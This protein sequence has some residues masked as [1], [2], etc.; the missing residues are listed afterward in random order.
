MTLQQI[1]YVLTINDSGT[2]ISAAEKLYISQPAL[3]ASLKD[4]EN[5]LG[6]RIFSRSPHGMTPTRDGASFIA[7]A[8]NLYQQYELLEDAYSVESNRRQE[9]GISTQHYSFVVQAFSQM[10]QDFDTGKYHFSL[11]ETTTTNII[12][13][14][15]EGRSEIGILYL[16]DYNSR[17]LKRLFTENQLEFHPLI[18]C[19]AYVYL[20][21]SH[22]LAD[23]SSITFEE[24]MDYPCLQFE[25]GSQGSSFLAEEILSDR[26]YLRTITTNDRATNLNLMKSINAYTLCSGIISEELN[27]SDYIAVP[28]HEDRRHRNQSM[29]IGYLIPRGS[30]LNKIGTVFIEEIQ[31]LLQQ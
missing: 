17:Y 14:V 27:G 21:K 31:K 29:T 26:E 10:L 23:R 28:F 1:R 15:A 8:R 18:K 16:S 2:M 4:L 9:F 25:Q 11:L 19:S 30:V 12:R 20:A 22:P 6:I 5:E 7:R 3:T 13:N 24:L